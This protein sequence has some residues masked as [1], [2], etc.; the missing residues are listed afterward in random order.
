MLL[1]QLLCL[2]LSLNLSHF[3]T[4]TRGKSLWDIRK[5]RKKS[6]TSSFDVKKCPNI[7]TM[8]NVNKTQLLGIW[9]AYITTPLDI[10]TYQRRCISHNVENDNFFKKNI[11]YTDYK[12]ICITYSCKYDA[13]TMLHRIKLRILTRTRTPLEE[14]LN[15]ALIF[16]EQI[17]FPSDKLEFLKADAFC[18]EWYLLKYHHKRRPG[19]YNVPTNIVWDRV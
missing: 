12:M 15:K 18:F 3:G 11:L 13:K 8:D 5:D 1:M 17:N 9:F 4:I 7:K 2:S 14:P 16:L 19:R 6:M 10:P